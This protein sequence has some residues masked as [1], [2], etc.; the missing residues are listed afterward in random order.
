MPTFLNLFIHFCLFF[1]ELCCRRCFN[2]GFELCAQKNVFKNDVLKKWVTTRL[3]STR[4]FLIYFF[5]YFHVV[6][7]DRGPWE[8]LPEGHRSVLCQS[9]QRQQRVETHQE[10]GRSLHLL[11]LVF[12][13]RT[14]I[15]EMRYWLTDKLLTSWAAQSCRVQCRHFYSSTRSSNHLT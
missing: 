15:N 4:M 6:C 3:L 14:K 2:L 7:Q 8:T 11:C 10:Q 13:S 1:P 5:F 9:L 12:H